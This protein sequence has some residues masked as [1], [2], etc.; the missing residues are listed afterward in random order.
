MK[1][2][3][4]NLDRAQDRRDYMRAE[5]SRLLPEAQVQ[6]AMAVD[7]KAPDWTPPAEY[8]PGRWR[9]D[10]WALGPS[11]IE[12]FRSHKDAWEKIA[13]S[14]ET[15]LVL[16]DDLLFSDQFGN[17]VQALLD[18]QVRGLIRLDATGDAV[19]CA[20]A[21]LQI[22]GAALHPL[23]SLGAS[24]AAY[25]LDA[26]TAGIL[27]RDA[28]IERTLD[29]YLFDPTPQERG[30]RGHGLEI[31]QLEPVIALQAQF[32]GFTSPERQVPEFLQVTKRV[33]VARRRDRRYTGP[34]LYRARKELLRTRHRK[35][36][37]KRI[38]ATLAQGGVYGQ[39]ATEP[40]LKWH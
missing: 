30:A 37:A 20:P 32:G 10:R 9:S 14:G 26:E 24:A 3:L 18:A 6:R 22:E 38:E 19:L 7:I 34:L 17:R 25:M 21:T 4:I 27:A 11:D 36:Q 40:D 35:A 28:R 39:I 16:E 2:F 29:D 23:K 13:A 8:R 12:I 15:G 5:L 1:I 33:D 31:L